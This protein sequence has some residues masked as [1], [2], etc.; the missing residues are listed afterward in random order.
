MRKLVAKA[1]ARNLDFFFIVSGSERTFTFRVTLNTLPTLTTLVRVII[2]LR[3]CA[4][5]NRLIL[6]FFFSSGFCSNLTIETLS[7]KSSSYRSFSKA[8]ASYSVRI[9]L[10]FF[11][12][13]N[14]MITKRCLSS[15]RD[16]FLRRPVFGLSSALHAF[17]DT[18]YLANSD[19]IAHLETPVQQE[20]LAC[21]S[22]CSCR[23][24]IP[25]L[26]AVEILEIQNGASSYDGAL[27]WNTLP[28][29]RDTRSYRISSV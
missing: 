24:T 7:D 12:S 8:C 6:F 16:S 18:L 28:E 1:F 20:M 3:L 14:D 21:D 2:T 26:S 27:L 15:L 9:L 22:P 4:Y 25:C 10:D 5:S 29:D 23:M 17:F 13:L 19:W 11:R